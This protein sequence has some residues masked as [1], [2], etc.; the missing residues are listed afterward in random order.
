MLMYDELIFEDLCELYNKDKDK[1]ELKRKEII[2]KFIESSNNK[3]KLKKLQ[4][5]IDV[6]RRN[7][8]PLKACIDISDEMWKSFEKLRYI[9]NKFSDEFKKVNN[10]NLNNRK[11][12][13][14]T[15]VINNSRIDSTH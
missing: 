4:W 5:K 11:K 13:H 8:K 6:L 10:D 15:L 1:F 2:N 9:L 3:K 12:N 7:K 14:L